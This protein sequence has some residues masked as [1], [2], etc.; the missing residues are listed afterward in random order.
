MKWEMTTGIEGKAA[1]DY[2]KRRLK[3]LVRWDTKLGV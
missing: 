2:S 3:I 1:G